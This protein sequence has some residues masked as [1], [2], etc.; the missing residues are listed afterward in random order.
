M[1]RLLD[2]GVIYANPYPA[3]WPVHAYYPNAVLLPSGHVLVF[4]GW[5][6]MYSDD[7]RIFQFRSADEGRTRT[8]EGVVWDGVGV[9]TTGQL[10]GDRGRAECLPV[11]AYVNRR[12]TG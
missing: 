11:G 2:G 5:A 10:L 12:L 7:G 3:D 8:N 4:A 9:G 6:A 1:L